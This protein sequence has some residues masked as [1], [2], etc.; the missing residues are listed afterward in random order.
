MRLLFSSFLTLSLLVTPLTALAQPS[1]VTGLKVEWKAKEGEIHLKWN[2]LQDKDIAYYEIFYSDESILSNDGEYDDFE[3][4]DGPDNEFIFTDIPAGEVLYFAVLGVNEDGEEGDL[5]VEEVSLVI[6]EESAKPAIPSQAAPDNGDDSGDGGS[7]VIAKPVTPATSSSSSKKSSSSVTS[8]SSKT[9]SSVSSVQSISS[10]SSV[11]IDTSPAVVTVPP[12]EAIAPEQEVVTTESSSS[13]SSAPLFNDGKIHLL[14]AETISATE[15]KLT[16]SHTATVL[17][18]DAPSAF[19][20]MDPFGRALKILSITIEDTMIIVRTATQEK[21]RVYQIQISEPL[22]GMGGL[23]LDKTNRQ[24]FFIGDS[25]GAE[26]TT[27]VVS[28]PPVPNMQG[29]AADV[30]AMNLIAAAQDDGLYIVTATWAVD[31]KAIPNAYV[32]QQSLDGGTTFSTPQILGGQISGVELRGV[33][34]GLFGLKVQAMNENGIPSQGVFQTIQ[35]AGDRSSIPV[36]RPP[37]AS[38]QPQTQIP[39]YSG[40]LADS[41][42]GIGMLGMGLAG[43][44]AGLRKARASKK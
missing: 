13:S 23:P 29:T 14:A 5:F 42:A 10:S 32:F 15:V 8:V 9:S 27:P 34:P 40:D 12:E 41:G 6:P 20:I 36:T 4:T 11:K 44:L 1:Q 43:A 17:P 16:F 2:K 22:T 3:I 25:A 37:L 24:A 35:L 7:N 39:N 19:R 21:G 18:K 30:S 33:V 38:V 28:P 31:T 26:A